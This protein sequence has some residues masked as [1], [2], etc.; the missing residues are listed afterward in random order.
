MGGGDDRW[1]KVQKDAKPF[2]SPFF[3][4]AFKCIGSCG[5]VHDPRVAERDDF[6]EF[7]ENEGFEKYLAEFDEG[8]GHVD[9]KL[10]K[11]AKVIGGGVAA[12]GGKLG[13]VAGDKLAAPM[14]AVKDGMDIAKDRVQEKVESAQA[15]RVSLSSAVKDRGD[16]V[17]AMMMNAQGKL[18]E[19]VKKDK[20]RRDK[21]QREK[22]AETVGGKKKKKYE[23]DDESDEDDKGNLEAFGSVAELRRLREK[24]L[25]NEGSKACA[26]M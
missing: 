19:R 20:D 15:R 26:V 3:W 6:G 23:D 9:G 5:G 1:E 2:A 18:Q 16:A 25:N 7:K 13:E 21:G 10:M 14:G 22:Q 17:R 8:E 12:A 4:A 24:R 11:G